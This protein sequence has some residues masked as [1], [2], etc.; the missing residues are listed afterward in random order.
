M[1]MNPV[2]VGVLAAAGDAA[3]ASISFL[4]ADKICKWWEKRK[5]RDTTP[6]RERWGMSAWRRYG[7]IGLGFTAPVLAGVLITTALGAA[8]GVPRGKLLIW[9]LAGIV[10]W[11]TLLVLAG[12]LG[13]S[14]FKALR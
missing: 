6:R 5:K 14:L 13:L 10:F 7:V 4:V 11:T 3:L 2:L 9:M 8:L 1:G 12:V